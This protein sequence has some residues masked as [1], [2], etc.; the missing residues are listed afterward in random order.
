MKRFKRLLPL[1][2]MA[3]MLSSCGKDPEPKETR[4]SILGNSFSSYEGYVNPET[5]AV[6]P[7]DGIGVTGPEQMWWSKVA[8]STGWTLER[9]NSFS[10]SLVCNFQDFNGGTYYAPN[11]YIRRM[12]N[13]GNPDVIFVFGATNDIYQ[14]APLGQ[15]AYADW[16][17]E[18]LCTFRPAM[19]YLIDGLKRLYP[20][21]VIYILVDME[22]C[23]NDHSIDEEIR[24]AYIESMHHI[25][26]HYHV[27]CIDIYGI[28][29]F[30][31]HPDVQGQ[32]DIARQVL[33]V[34]LALMPETILHL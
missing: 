12:D 25:A 22:L 24:E 10:G 32:D 14:G 2:A 3:L 4:F 19:S 21:A 15:Y 8:V 1:F 28:H 29:K 9:N 20:K 23:I 30:A 17:E 34:V 7:Y 26:S 27:D 33:E 18:Q 6:F 5:N 31:W 11:S 13:L 16:T